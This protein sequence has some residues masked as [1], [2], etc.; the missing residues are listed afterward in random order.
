[1]QHTK[2]SNMMLQGKEMVVIYSELHTKFPN[3]FF[4]QAQYEWVLFI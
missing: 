1:M 2:A 3:R 4:V